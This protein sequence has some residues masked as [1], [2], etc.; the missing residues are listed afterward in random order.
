MIE[1][2]TYQIDWITKLKKNLGTRVDPKLIE[3]TI[4]ILLFLKVI[5]EEFIFK[6]VYKLIVYKLKR[7]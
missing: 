7:F 5:N 6:I 2:K 1:P 4:I 3:I